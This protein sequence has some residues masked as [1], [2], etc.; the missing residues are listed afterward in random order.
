[1]LRFRHKKRE[2]FE[3]GSGDRSWCELSRGGVDRWT[4]IGRQF[5]PEGKSV[6]YGRCS[7]NNWKNPA[8]GF[9]LKKFLDPPLCTRL[10][11]CKPSLGAAT[12]SY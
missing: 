10:A 1:M 6:L 11:R 8:L 3:R 9:P 12:Q 4:K 7:A 5:R 2:F